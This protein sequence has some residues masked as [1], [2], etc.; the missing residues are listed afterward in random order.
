MIFYNS[1]LMPDSHSATLFM[2]SNAKPFTC[3]EDH[4]AGIYLQL[5]TLVELSVESGENPIGLIEDYLG[6][7]YTEGKAT[8]DIAFFLAYTDR[9]QNALWSLQLRWQEK[10][11]IVTTES[12]LHGGI[13]KDQAIQLFTQITLRVYLE[14]LSNYTDE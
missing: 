9:V 12:Y 10:S 14:A 2:V 13:S 8:A 6:I 4:E 5:H 1:E 3:F 11:D 7:T